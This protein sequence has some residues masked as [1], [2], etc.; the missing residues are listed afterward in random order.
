MKNKPNFFFDNRGFPNWQQLLAEIDE[1]ATPWLQPAL[2]C[3]TNMKV[4]I[5]RNT[6]YE[7]S[8]KSEDE[9]SQI[10]GWE[11]CDSSVFNKE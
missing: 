10:G 9:V 11:K 5:Q 6:L 8:P 1:R 3:R 4:R 7:M 2:L